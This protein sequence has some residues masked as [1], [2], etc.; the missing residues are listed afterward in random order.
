MVRAG[1]TRISPHDIAVL[2]SSLP[3]SFCYP[4]GSLQWSS[5]GE[6]KDGL[7]HMVA[8]ESQR[9]GNVYRGGAAKAGGRPSLSR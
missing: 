5:R 9:G 1:R 4:R 3:S 8:D 6:D 7:S 2:A